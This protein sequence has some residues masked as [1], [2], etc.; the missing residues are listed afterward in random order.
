MNRDNKA[1]QV[2]SPYIQANLCSH[3]ITSRALSGTKLVS[4]AHI[5]VAVSI[6][7]KEDLAY[8]WSI[9]SQGAN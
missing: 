1:D 4:G 5:N 3:C 9:G 8:N 7:Y 2:L 6:N